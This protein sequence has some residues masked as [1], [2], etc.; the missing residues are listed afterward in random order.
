MS[1][2]RY[3]TPLRLRLNHSPRL[4]MIFII[5]FLLCFISVMLTQMSLLV[6]SLII[7]ILFTIAVETWCYRS[8]LGGKPC[9]LVLRPDGEWLLQQDQSEEK[10][11]LLGE[12]TFGYSL[13]ILAFV[14]NR[15]K[16]W[17]VIWRS[18]C[19]YEV[20]RRLGVYLNSHGRC[21]V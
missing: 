19:V 17:F 1:S 3:A 4:R 12:T 10:L 14:G 18:E 13:I 15:K 2:P 11:Q 6:S 8:E 21:E 16:R 20:Y 7:V 5:F 9:E